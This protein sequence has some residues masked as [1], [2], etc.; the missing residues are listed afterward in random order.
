MFHDF[1]LIGKITS[2]NFWLT[3]ALFFFS[4][5][6][7]SLS[8]LYQMGT[9]QFVLD[10]IRFQYSL[11]FPSLL[12]LQSE[13]VCWFALKILLKSLQWRRDSCIFARKW[14]PRYHP[15]IKRIWRSKKAYDV[16][17]AFFTFSVICRVRAKQFSG[18]S[19]Q[20]LRQQ[21]CTIKRYEKQ[22]LQLVHA[23]TCSGWVLNN[24]CRMPLTDDERIGGSLW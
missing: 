7:N 10:L 9:P 3:D 4:S 22:S 13:A 11:L 19:L 2:Q 8:V 6:L 18:L 15:Y 21:R 23:Y 16:L 17:F 14:S 5:N 1:V 24:N 20:Q 12:C